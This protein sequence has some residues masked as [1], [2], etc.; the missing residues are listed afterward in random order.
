M[1]EKKI[2]LTGGAGFIG[3]HL[4][5]RLLEMGKEVTVYDNL[6]S[7]KMENIRHNMGK[8]GFNFIKADLLDT[9]ALKEAMTGHDLVWHLGANTDIPSGIDDVQMDLKNCTIAT[10]NIL[11]TMRQLDINKL[12]F[13]SSSAIYG[14]IEKMPT[15]ESDGP[16][17]PISLYGAGKLACEGFVSAYCHL[18]DLQAWMFRFGN[19]VGFGMGHGV[20]YDFIHKL[21]NNPEEMEI[22]GDGTQEK[23]YFVVEDC[24]D[25]MFHAFH[26][27]NSQCDVFNLGS[28]STV[29]VSVIAQI[30]AQEMALRDVEFRYTGGKRGWPGDVPVVKF[31]L[32]KIKGLGWEAKHSSEEAVRIAAQ[33]LLGKEWG[34][35]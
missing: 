23:N 5:D 21:R 15:A 19:V 9:K 24:I 34:K 3:S 20:I 22:L 4:A 29:K 7:G 30:V 35:R 16:I 14:E 10:H 25:G 33:R 6:F 32:S 27:S 31:D 18:F 11:E 2:L 12:L 26:T 28:E 13:T 1:E 8:T 17:L